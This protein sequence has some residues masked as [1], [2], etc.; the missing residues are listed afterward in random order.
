[1]NTMRVVL[2]TLCLCLSACGDKPEPP[3]QVQ[4]AWVRQ[5]PAGSSMTAA[6]ATIYNPSNQA[7]ELVGVEIDS[8]RD[9]EIH[10]TREVDGVSRMR[11]VD[12]LRID[13]GSTLKLEPGGIHIMAM[14]RQDLSESPVLMRFIFADGSLLETSA[15]WRRRAPESE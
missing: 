2:V 4:Q 15:E 9:A 5:V 10:E 13:P 7:R 8:F 3:L 14:G 11:P 12:K 6:Y 1:M